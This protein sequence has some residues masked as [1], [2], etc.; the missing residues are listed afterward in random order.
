M[1]YTIE[2]LR[3]PLTVLIDGKKVVTEGYAFMDERGCCMIIIYGE[4]K[5]DW[6][7]DKLKLK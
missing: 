7:D 4:A 1:K 5:K 6:L 3:E 2:K